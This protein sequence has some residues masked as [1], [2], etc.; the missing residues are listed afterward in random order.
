[1]WNDFAELSID[2]LDYRGKKGEWLTSLNATDVWEVS[3]WILV[4]GV[5]MDV[6]LLFHWNEWV[7]EHLGNLIQSEKKSS[8]FCIG[9]WLAPSSSDDVAVMIINTNGVIVFILIRQGG[10]VMNDMVDVGCWF[11]I[12]E[13]VFGENLVWRDPDEFSF[14][15]PKGD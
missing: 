2:C 13:S 3:D 6:A 1:M 10:E 14:T 11:G 7:S 8:R 15:S 4:D 12:N 5:A 9:S